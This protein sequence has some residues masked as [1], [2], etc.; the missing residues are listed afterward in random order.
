MTKYLLKRL[1]HGAVSVV[2]VVGIVMVMIYSMLDRNLIFAND[3][4]YTHQSNNNRISYTY[5]TWETYGYV[6]YVPYSDYLQ[7]LIK[8]GELS[9]E[10]YSAVSSVG[11]TADKDSEETARYIAQFTQ[12]YESQGYQ[13][14]RYDAVIRSG[15]VAD[16][17]RAILFAYRNIPVMKRMLSYFTNLLDV[18]NIHDIDTVEGEPGLTFTLYDPVYG[19]EK[20]SPAVIGNGTTHKYLIYFDNRFPYFHQNLL[21]LNLGMSY[22]VNAGVDVFTTMTQAQ[23]SYV[24]SVI[25]YP[26]GL[27]ESSADDLHTAT[28]SQGSRESSLVYETRYDDDYTV[29]QL[30][31]GG[32]SRMGYSFVIG[33][34]EIILAY[35]IGL[36][37]GILMARKKDKLVDKLGTAYVVFIMAVPSLSYIFIFKAIGGKLGLPTTFDLDRTTKL[38]YILPIASLAA[39]SIAGLMKWMR[40]YMIDQMNSD[41]VKFARSGGLS[42]GEIFNKHIMKNA[43]IPLVHSIPADVIYAMTGA[44]ITERVYSVPGAGRMLIEAINKYDNTVIVGMVLFYAV[45]SV[46]ALALGDCAMALVDPRISFDTK[47]R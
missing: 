34:I 35:L 11:S 44:M 36:P 9:E 5:A 19:G 45:L 18:D 25:T 10:E 27:T 24:N 47:A 40:R 17:G 8:N 13:V 14:R 22:A 32:K 37:V 33:I 6:D 31:R 1:L 41:Y 30:V 29:V 21:T 3:S 38:M 46:V 4:T 42:E 43:I 2:I 16:G 7:E 15:K 23:G 20:F 26:T 28:Y 12:Y 39:T